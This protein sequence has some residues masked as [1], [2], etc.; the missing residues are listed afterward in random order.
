MNTSLILDAIDHLDE[1][2]IEKH[3]MTKKLFQKKKAVRRKRLLTSAAC[4]LVIAMTLS[5][6][7]D[8]IRPY[9]VLEVSGFD[10]FV[11]A[12]HK[13]E[14][15]LITSVYPNIF[16]KS[17]KTIC[18][19]GVDWDVEYQSSTN[20]YYYK[21][22]VDFYKKSENGS[23]VQIGVNCSTGRIDSYSWVD[24]NY[25]NEKQNES[26]LTE[27]QCLAIAKAYLN[28]YTD[29][30]AYEMVAVR[31]LKIPEYGGLY[32]FEL[33]RTINGVETSD[34]AYIGVTVFGDVVSHLFTSL[35][36]MKGARLPSDVELQKIEALVYE[37]LDGIYENVADQYEISY[38]I[39]KK[40]FIRL[41]NGKYAMQYDVDVSLFTSDS[42]NPWREST[43]F[44]IYTK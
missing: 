35:G 20:G 13:A 22:H 8:L 32:D 5:V 21:S 19:N 3:F 9:R 6:L 23:Q 11:H 17:E 25:A 18:V 1:S 36:E 10:N 14:I 24:R 41:S 2:L 30:D 31:D 38:D 28:D 42:I 44:I 37:K 40:S 7:I 15:D 39:I 16:M 4:F 26:R 27:E 12:E 33:T 43:K 29:A 34:R